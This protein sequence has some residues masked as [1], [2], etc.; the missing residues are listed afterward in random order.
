MRGVG[1]YKRLDE[2]V[3]DDIQFLVDEQGPDSTLDLGV[4]A[5]P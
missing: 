2:I 5:R 4:Q 3:A 1:L